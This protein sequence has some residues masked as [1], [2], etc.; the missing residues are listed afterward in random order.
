MNFEKFMK[1]RR[2]RQCRGNI[3]TGK[4]CKSHGLI[5]GFCATHFKIMRMKNKLLLILLLGI[6]FIGFISATDSQL[7]IPC[8]GDEQLYIHCLGDD[9]LNNFG[10]IEKEQPGVSQI[11]E[12]KIIN[13]SKGLIYFILFLLF[14]F[15][16]L[17]LILSFY[18]L[19]KYSQNKSFKNY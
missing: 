13:F 14:L 8:G 6:F 4:E 3:K 15:I 17:F 18:F 7:I 16:F 9:Q 5:N 2:A 10:N 12:E 1:Q 19:K 11:T